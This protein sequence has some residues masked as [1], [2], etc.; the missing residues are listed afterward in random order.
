MS[1]PTSHITPPLRNY[2]FLRGFSPYYEWP[3]SHALITIAPLVYGPPKRAELTERF[4]R[5]HVLSVDIFA[6]RREATGT[7]VAPLSVE[8]SIELGLGEK[9]TANVVGFNCK[10]AHTLFIPLQTRPDSSRLYSR[11]DH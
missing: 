3:R 5:D 8:N 2:K 7:V 11:F 4:L 9:V 10:A 1:T 6:L